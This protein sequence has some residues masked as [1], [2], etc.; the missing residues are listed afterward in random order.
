MGI[1]GPTKKDGGLDIRFKSNRGGYL[2]KSIRAASTL[3]QYSKSSKSKPAPPDKNQLKIWW[4]RKSNNKMR[5][6]QMNESLLESMKSQEYLDE[7]NALVELSK[8][9]EEKYLDEINELVQQS[10][11]FLR[12]EGFATLNNSKN[13]YK[14]EQSLINS[15]KKTFVG[16]YVRTKTF[17]TFLDLVKKEATRLNEAGNLELSKKVIKKYKNAKIK[18]FLISGNLFSIVVA[19]LLFLFFIILANQ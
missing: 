9:D 4:T 18:A 15:S 14:S 12:R 2:G 13:E 17:K 11:E 8:N 7:H 1:F 3:Y 19:T 16:Y 6:R 5:D 10:F